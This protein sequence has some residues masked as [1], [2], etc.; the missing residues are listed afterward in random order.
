MK[1]KKIPPTHPGEVLEE[2]FLKPMGITKYRLAMTIHV[3]P[4]RIGEIIKGSRSI[5][6]DTAIRLALYFKTSA[7]FWLGLQMRYDL[8]KA[9]DSLHDTL[10]KEIKPYDAAA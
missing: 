2:E 10:E 6:A 4:Q 8:E 9:Q 1:R 3:P 7:E 5:T